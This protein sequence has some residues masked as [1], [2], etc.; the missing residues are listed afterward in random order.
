MLIGEAPG[1]VEDL[2]GTPFV[3][4]SGQLLRGM[5]Q[6]IHLKP[7]DYYISNT[8]KCR[9]PKN[10]DPIATEIHNCTSLLTAEIFLV[11]PK[12]IVCVGRFG[13]ALL[14]NE[15]P[16]NITV[17]KLRG[18][19]FETTINFFKTEIMLIYHPAY[20]ARGKK[21]KEKQLTIEDLK[22]AKFLA[23]Q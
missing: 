3:G 2:R 11:K 10:R 19:L 6:S 5:L 17:G 15:E 21:E 7:S 13:F 4:R 8:L 18:L 23:L 16:N 20:L 14:L 1:E 12:I 22:I 9:P